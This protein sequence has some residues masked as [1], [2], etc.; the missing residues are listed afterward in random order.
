MPRPVHI[1][2][3]RQVL[4]IE[5]LD[6]GPSWPSPAAARSMSDPGVAA[7]LGAVMAGWHRATT[8][9]GLWPSPALGILRLPDALEHAVQGRSPVTRLLM[10]SLAGDP[11]LSGA[12]RSARDRMARSVS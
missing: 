1:D 11:E 7:R 8:D 3:Q 9:A 2:E 12:L 6:D 10:E 4:V 5:S